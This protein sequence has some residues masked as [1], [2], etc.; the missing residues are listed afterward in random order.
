MLNFSITKI[1]IVLILATVLFLLYRRLDHF[2]DCNGT[3]LKEGRQLTDKKGN[4][5]K[6]IYIPPY[7]FIVKPTEKDIYYKAIIDKN[8]N[9]AIKEKNKQYGEIDMEE[10]CKMEKIGQEMKNMLTKNQ[11]TIVNTVRNTGDKVNNNPMKVV[12]L[13]DEKNKNKSN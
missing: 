10:M 13:I 7:S 11:K 2:T 4:K 8:G 9:Y 6:I 12:S 1:I 3:E 5:Y